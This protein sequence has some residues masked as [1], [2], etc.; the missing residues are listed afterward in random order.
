MNTPIRLTAKLTGRLLESSVIHYGGLPP[1][2]TG[3]QDLRKRM[4]APVLLVIEEKSEGVF[5]SR[6]TA[7]GQEVGDTWHRSAEEA[8]E[9]ARFEYG[10]L[11]GDWKL[12][13]ADVDDVVSF[14]LN[15]PP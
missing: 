11:L 1:Q 2:L 15:A 7:D 3:G 13:P 12:V 14:G 4:K 10:E 6:F 5:L 8:Q 9:Q